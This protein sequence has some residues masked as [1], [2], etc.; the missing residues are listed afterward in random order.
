MKLNMICTKFDPK[1]KK[2]PKHLHFG[3]LSFLKP[4]NPTFLEAIFQ[5]WLGIICHWMQDEIED[6]ISVEVDHLGC[7]FLTQLAFHQL[8]SNV[9]QLFEFFNAVTECQESST[10]VLLQSCQQFTMLSHGPLQR[11]DLSLLQQYQWRHRFQPS[12]EPSM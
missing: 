11:T 1:N 8:T 9:K 4:E 12:V 2:N 7:D 3:L 5:L 10:N 6:E